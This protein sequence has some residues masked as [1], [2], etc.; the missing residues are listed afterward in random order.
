MIKLRI[1]QEIAII[2][3][4]REFINKISGGGFFG[5]TKDRSSEDYSY[6]LDTKSLHDLNISGRGT[7]PQLFT[8]AN[9]FQ[10][11]IKAL[12]EGETREK[13]RRYF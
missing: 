8:N 11:Y 4:D 12:Y 5:F 7:I 1:Y 10:Y 3:D 13:Y 9:G 2:N 6:H